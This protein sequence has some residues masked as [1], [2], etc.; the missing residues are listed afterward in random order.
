M[1]TKRNFLKSIALGTGLVLSEGFLNI[2]SGLENKIEKSLDEV[3]KLQDE[4]KKNI[5]G[6]N[7]LDKNYLDLVLKNA[8]NMILNKTNNS[9]YFFYIDRNPDKQL[10]FVYFFDYLDKNVTL[11][12]IDKIS[13]GN[14][15]RR[16]HFIT[17][18]GIYEN[19][20]KN[21][22]Y[23]ALGTKNDEGW[24]GLGA[25]DSRVW[26]FGWQKTDYNNENRDIRLLMHA[27]D[28]FFGEKRLGKVDSKGCIRISSK[29]NKFLDH[30]GILD[31]EYE[32]Q[33]Y[34]KNISWLLNPN[35]EP[36]TYAGKYLLISDSKSF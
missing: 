9:Q 32:E 7:I 2:A 25:K 13:T 27:T 35:R 23:R 26:D 15:K 4:F 8:T 1:I 16:G 11:I 17:P 20:I 28:P 33:K 24:M 34:L 36:V 30:Y 6:N 3:K 5:N 19:T 29:L 31:K 10:G 21:F 12:G 18:I 22:S 14:P